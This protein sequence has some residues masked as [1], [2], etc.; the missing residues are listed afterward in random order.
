MGSS[1][2]KVT[3]IA[4]FMQYFLYK[5][6]FFYVLC[7]NN[8]RFKHYFFRFLVQFWFSALP[9]IKLFTLFYKVFVR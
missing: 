6:R 1:P 5:S 2:D 9:F 3:K 4:V 7:K 8:A